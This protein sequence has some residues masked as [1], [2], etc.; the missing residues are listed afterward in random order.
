MIV[1]QIMWISPFHQAYLMGHLTIPRKT[2]IFQ[3]FPKT[4]LKGMG[5]WVKNTILYR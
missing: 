1:D 2:T 4:G 5:E 3:L